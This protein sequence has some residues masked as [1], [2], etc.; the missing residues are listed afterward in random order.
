M[1]FVNK[2]DIINNY[3]MISPICIKPTSNIWVCQKIEDE[4]KV[5]VKIISKE[6]IELSK[7]YNQIIRD[8]SIMKQIHS[9]YIVEFYED[10]EDIKNYYIFME[11]CELGDLENYLEKKGK[12]SETL[13]KQF[14]KDIVYSIYY[15]HIEKK[16][17]HRDISLKNILITKENKI[18]LAD[19]GFSKNFSE[20]NQTFLTPCGTPAFTSPEII[21]GKHYTKATDIW[22][23]GILLYRMLTNTYPFEEENISDLF[24]KIVFSD[25]RFPNF[26][27]NNVIDLLKK[28]LN[29]SPFDRLSIE[30]IK[31]H[32]FLTTP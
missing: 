19:F 13:C 30:K 17:V 8:I 16:I 26:L 6:S 12:L 4:I 20:N 7:Q 29:K 28:I 14:F 31:N 27:S 5:A 24:K 2:G 15:L 23:L 9:S 11:Y 32:P 21:K 18:K 1:Y 3:I 22:S 10:F 25:I